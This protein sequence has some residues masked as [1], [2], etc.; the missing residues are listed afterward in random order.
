MGRDVDRDAGRGAHVEAAEA[1]REGPAVR[2]A[3]QDDRAGAE[4]EAPVERAA[5]GRAGQV[6]DAAAQGD[7]GLQAAQM[8]ARQG[9]RQIAE[10]GLQVQ[11]ELGSVGSAVTGRWRPWKRV[12]AVRIVSSGA[13]S[14]P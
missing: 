6:E 10:A 12:A 3:G 11:V 4:A 9:D 13:R 7:I 8:G 5:E 1:R 2:P 14:G